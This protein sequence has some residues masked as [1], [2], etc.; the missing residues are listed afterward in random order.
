[1]TMQQV[2][3]DGTAGVVGGRISRML[4]HNAAVDLGFVEDGSRDV[5]LRAAGHDPSPM[6]EAVRQDVH[7]PPSRDFLLG[8]INVETAIGFGELDWQPSTGAV[9]VREG[10]TG[11]PLGTDR[12]DAFACDRVAE[13]ARST[14]APGDGVSS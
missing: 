4:E 14:V 1:M 13:R 12:R 3:I 10:A 2:A 6:H 8:D 9:H 5:K 11:R 7:E